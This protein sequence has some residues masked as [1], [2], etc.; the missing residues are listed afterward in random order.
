MPL[1][2]WLQKQRKEP[3]LCL[4][5]PLRTATAGLPE[6]IAGGC[7]LRNAC[8]ISMLHRYVTACAFLLRGHQS[9]ARQATSSNHLVWLPFRILRLIV[10]ICPLHESIHDS[11]YMRP[12]PGPRLW[13][14]LT[15][16][17]LA[18]PDCCLDL[19]AKLEL[20]L[21]AYYLWHQKHR[22]PPAWKLCDAFVSCSGSLVMSPA[23]PHV[24]C[25]NGEQA[26]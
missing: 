20:C 6:R 22:Y 8:E 26:P 5:T 13:F 25:M 17:S 10:P 3:A 23:V 14:R 7:D 16:D 9:N 15:V 19:V 1:R 12:G 2:V 11:R 4:S 18:K 21:A 24:L